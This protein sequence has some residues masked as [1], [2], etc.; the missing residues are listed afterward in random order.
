MITIR[1]YGGE[2][3]V[4]PVR[5]VEVHPVEGV[6]VEVLHLHAIDFLVTIAVEESESGLRQSDQSSEGIVVA[7][8]DDTAGCTEDYRYGED[9]NGTNA[10][11]SGTRHVQRCE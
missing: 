4:D 1:I 5:V 11:P 10:R 9:E 8:D 6:T 7:L 3:L 2:D